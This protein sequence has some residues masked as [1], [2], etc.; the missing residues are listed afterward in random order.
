MSSIAEIF[1]F[2]DFF[3]SGPR[4]GEICDL[5]AYERANTS[6]EKRGCVS[7]RIRI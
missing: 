6:R 2:R 1:G 4:R 3:V 7:R 5:K